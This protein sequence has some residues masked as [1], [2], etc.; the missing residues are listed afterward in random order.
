MISCFYIIS[1][2]LDGILS[3]V[4]A[5][6]LTKKTS[7]SA[8][9]DPLDVLALFVSALCHDVDHPGNTNMFQVMTAS[10]LASHYNDQSVLENHHCSVTFKTLKEEESNFMAHIPSNKRKVFRKRVIGAILATDMSHHFSM[11]NDLDSIEKEGFGQSLR[12]KLKEDDELKQRVCD[13]L[14]H[15]ADLTANLQP[16]PIAL[17]WAKRVC[18]EF[19]NQTIREKELGLESS[20]MMLG[21]EDEETFLKSQVVFFGFMLKPLFRS[22]TR[23]WPKLNYLY[24][25]LVNN[26]E[27]IRNEL[28]TI[29]EDNRCRCRSSSI[30]LISS[31]SERLPG[32]KQC[33]SSS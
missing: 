8:Q 6:S 26:E 16:L 20:A 5:G 24:L 4:A 13:V 23:L 31:L 9:M 11:C 29:R 22:V 15:T 2:P 18:E 33:D 17:K 3:H 1:P 14:L 19:T 12:L 7:L 10:D 30:H 25:N 32:Q 27:V 28:Q 21:L